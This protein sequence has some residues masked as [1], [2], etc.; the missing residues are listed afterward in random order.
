M[1]KAPKAAAAGEQPPKSKKMLI[2]IIAV[3]VLLAGGGAAAFFLLKPHP[4]KGGEA[5]AEEHVEEA[6]AAAPA[7]Y[8]ELGTFTANLIHEEGDRYLQITISLKLSS[9]EM[10]EKIKASNPEILH[11]VNMLLQS[12]RPSELSTVAGK[13]KLAADLKAHINYVLG[14]IKVAPA[15]VTSPAPEAATEGAAEQ[16]HAAAHEAGGEQAGTHEA[17]KGVAEVLFTS[18][19]IQ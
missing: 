5:A 1:S 16:P 3:V 6:H 17:G 15:I 19:I 2:I 8:M 14:F 12:K 13:E 18:F 9:P 10:E 4:P 7:K 11:R